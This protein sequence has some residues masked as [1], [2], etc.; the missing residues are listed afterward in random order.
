VRVTLYADR[1][2]IAPLLRDHSPEDALAA[3]YAL[4]HSEIRTKLS[5]HRDK[6]GAKRADGFMAVCQTGFDLFQPLVILRAPT[7]EI[8]AWLLRNGLEPA[9]SYHLIVPPALAPAVEAEMNTQAAATHLLF[10]AHRSSFQPVINVMVT[11]SRGPDGGPRFAIRAADGSVVAESGTNWRTDE[12]AEVFVHVEFAARGRGL[13]K[14]VVSACTAHL[15]ESNLRPLYFVD[16]DN[17][18]SVAIAEAL[19]YTDTGV[20]ERAYV[21]SLRHIA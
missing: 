15:L 12:F 19:G 9:R 11:S 5:V 20:R 14:S 21:G 18:E 17:A 7:T 4:H 3:Y 8:A 6:R 16:Q 10:E 2:A 1:Q 13:G